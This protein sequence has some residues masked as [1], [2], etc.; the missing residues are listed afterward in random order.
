MKRVLVIG[1]P[2]SGKSTFARRLSEM[3]GFPLVYLDMLFHKADRTTCSKEEFDEQLIRVLERDEWILDGNYART[4]G[5]RLERC[6]TVFW[7]DYPT[8]VCLAGVRSRRGKPREDMPWVEMEEDEEF[9][10]YIKNFERDRKPEIEDMLGRVEGKEVHVFTSR[11]M[12]EEYFK[13]MKER[14]WKSVSETE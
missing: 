8:E 2:G 5:M 12:A 10:E 14:G 13:G 1:C 6:D 11:E 4:L 3:T 9:M 7:L